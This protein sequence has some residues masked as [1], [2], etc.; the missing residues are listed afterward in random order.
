MQNWKEN[1]TIARPEIAENFAATVWKE[2]S[3]T[4]ESIVVPKKTWELAV[5]T[6]SSDILARE[7][8]DYERYRAIYN[9]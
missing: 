7:K 3:E 5:K 4:E 6:L 1:F 9:L 2:A 8:F